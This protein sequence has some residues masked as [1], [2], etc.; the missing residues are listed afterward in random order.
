MFIS[1]DQIKNRFGI[2]IE[3]GRL[4]LAQAMVEAFVGR[5]ESQIDDG[6]DMA[7]LGNATAFQ[8]IYLGNNYNTILEQAAV[9]Q[10]AQ[11]DAVSSFVKEMYAPFMAPMAVLACR[12]LSWKGTRTIKTGKILDG[13][14]PD[15]KQRWYTE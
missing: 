15:W 13:G 2:D 12:N 8:A 3:I 9:T 7:L 11:G 5:V 6:K 1:R 4:E 14:T 10:V